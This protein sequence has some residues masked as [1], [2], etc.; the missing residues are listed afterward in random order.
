MKLSLV[1]LVRGGECQI[2][3]ST[4]KLQYLSQL[5]LHLREAKITL[6]NINSSYIVHLHFM[7]ETCGRCHPCCCM[8][9]SLLSAVLFSIG[10]FSDS[11]HM[12]ERVFSSCQRSWWCFTHLCNIAGDAVAF[13]LFQPRRKTYRMV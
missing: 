5:F 2:L 8:H 7:A 6:G 11:L 3:L 10:L 12:Q 9:N 13:A 4:S 1:R